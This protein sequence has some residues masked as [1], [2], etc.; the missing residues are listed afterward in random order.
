MIP[1]RELNLFKEYVTNMPARL[2]S[3]P[4]W[5]KYLRENSGP[6]GAYDAALRQRRLP[7]FREMYGCSIDGTGKLAY[8]ADFERRNGNIVSRQTGKE[9][10]ECLT[11]EDPRPQ[12][13]VETTDAEPPDGHGIHGRAPPT[14]PFDRPRRDREEPMEPHHMATDPPTSEAQAK[15][16]YAAREGRSTLGI[17]KSVGE[18]FVGKADAALGEIETGQQGREVGPELWERTRGRDQ[19]EHL[20]EPQDEKLIRRVLRKLGFKAADIDEAIARDRRG[21]RR[22]AGD[23]AL[24]RRS[25]H[26]MFPETERLESHGSGAV[27]FTP[28]VFVHRS[29]G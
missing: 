5:S 22:M 14:G 1:Q 2:Q 20:D 28:R 16:M 10:P 4:G 27:A 29:R 13:E 24:A 18:H 19:E 26:H 15:A 11:D 21:R 17:P 9:F 6:A 25:F 23:R 3:G 12:A 8:D 7:S